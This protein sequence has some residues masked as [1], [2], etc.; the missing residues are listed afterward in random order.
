[1]P[2]RL[3]VGVLVVGSV[4]LGAGLV[5]WANAQGLLGPHGKARQLLSVADRAAAAGDTT[6][7]QATLEELI[8]TYPD[9][10]W[11]DKA[12]LKLGEVNEAQQH[13]LE[14]RT[15]Y[16]LLLERFA[17][18]NSAAQAQ[19]RLGAVNV[20]LLFSP[21]ATEQDT[22]YEVKSGDSLG[23][24]AETHHTTVELLKRANGLSSDVIQ[25][26]QRLKVPDARFAIV[27]DKSDNQMLLTAD[28]QFFKLYPVATGKENSTPTGTFKIINKIVKP[29]WYR[30]GAVVPP[31]SPE[32][33]LGP[34]W[35]GFDKKGYGIH[36]SVD[37][38]AIGQ[39]VTAGCVRMHNADVE[40]LFAIVPTGTEVTV[41]D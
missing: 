34:R 25:P 7:A 8:G 2:R 3:V 9:S 38:S 10:P 23:R 15:A 24:I 37:D 26:K 4:V 12:L 14:A 11:T 41:V 32:N 31:D 35:L 36:G 30:Q 20:Q 33:I 28:N 40:E 21:T 22:P 19:A 16:K 27:V 29:V 6:Q 1:M 17:G 13:W 39:Q 18:S 5:V